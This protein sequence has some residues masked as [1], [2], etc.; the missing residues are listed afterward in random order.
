MST[1]LE[2][3]QDGKRRVVV[4]KLGSRVI[5]DEGDGPSR[6][7]IN[8]FCIQIA[9]LREHGIGVVVITSGAVKACDDKSCSDGL[10]A[11]VGQPDLMGM[12]NK[13]LPT[14]N[15]GGEKYRVAQFLPDERQLNSSADFHL[16]LHEALAH[17]WYIPFINYNDPMDSKATGPQSEYADND[18]VM[19]R[20]CNSVKRVADEVYG[21]ICFDQRGFIDEKGRKID[22]L[23][24]YE[25]EKIQQSSWWKHYVD[26][27]FK[28]KVG[29]LNRLTKVCEH[30]QLVPGRA[31]NAI[32]R[33]VEQQKGF[34]TMFTS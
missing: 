18:P 14:K 27:R 23:T 15:K 21:I 6:K 30:V 31:K 34:G 28:T 16:H 1:K 9:H 11:A 10:R 2:R 24:D 33:A 25:V 5:C 19:W 7:F 22:I 32:I 8:Q 4:I 12:Y 17:R 26:P 13:Y 20:I 29:V 3:L